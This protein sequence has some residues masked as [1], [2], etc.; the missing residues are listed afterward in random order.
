MTNYNPLDWYWIVGGDETKV[1]SSNAG[2]YVASDA[3]EG[4]ATVTANQFA[5]ALK[6]ML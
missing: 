2:D 5:N 6:A 4:K 3:L 1:Y